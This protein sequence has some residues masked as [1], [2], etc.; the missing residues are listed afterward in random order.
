MISGVPD[1]RDKSLQEGLDSSFTYC[2]L[3]DPIDPEKMLTG[4]ALPDYSSLA[5]YLLHACLG[6]SSGQANLER[7][8]EDGLFYSDGDT[9]YYL[10]Y[11]P[12]LAFLESNG[13]MLDAERAKR[14]QEAGQPASEGEKRRKA[15][16]YGA[17]K[18]LDQEDL[19]EFGIIFCQ[20][21]HE[22]HRQGQ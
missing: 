22:M 20:L 17:G 19:Q 2:T 5:A 7:K 11:Q 4:A 9:D 8:N 10:L 21:P 18:Y 16:V 13:A 14:I 15:V 3:G 6:V 12:D 1:T